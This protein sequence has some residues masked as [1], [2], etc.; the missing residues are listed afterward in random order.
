MADVW[1]VL[2]QSA[3]TAT[4]LTDVYTVPAEKVATV[5]VVVC[6]Q[7][8]AG[9]TFR[10]AI[11]PEGAADTQAHYLYYDAAIGA[12]STIT[13]GKLTV[14]ATDKIR[15]YASSGNFSITVNGIEE[16]Q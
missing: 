15:V 12:N 5:D 3:P 11:A 1:G 4:T 14:S 2:G 7:A 10:L 6:N 9:A 13:T 8:G 16:D